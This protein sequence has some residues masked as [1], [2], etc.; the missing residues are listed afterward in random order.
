VIKALLDAAEVDRGAAALGLEVIPNLITVC[1]TG[2][3]LLGNWSLTGGSGAC[4]GRGKAMRLASGATGERRC[5][6]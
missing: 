2:A 3:F 5:R 6:Q 1:R 4:P